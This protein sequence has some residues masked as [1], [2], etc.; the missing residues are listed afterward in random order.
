MKYMIRAKELSQLLN[1]IADQ[2]ETVDKTEKLIV[3]AL[4]A[5]AQAI[6]EAADRVYY[7]DNTEG[8][9][10]PF[11]VDAFFVECYEFDETDDQ[12]QTSSEVESETPTV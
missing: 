10:L 3:M 11:D 12:L 2:A 9:A 4:R 8:L 1:M 5:G 7:A 6:D